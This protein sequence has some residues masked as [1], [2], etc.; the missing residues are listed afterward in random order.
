MLKKTKTPGLETSLR[1]PIPSLLS[2]FAFLFIAALLSIAGCAK[3]GEPQPPEIFIPEAAVDLTANQRAD[4]ILLRV[5]IPR[6]NTN[7]SEVTTL[8]NVDVYRHAA[9]TSRIRHSNPISADQFWREAEQILSI[10]ETR[11]SEYAQQDLL[12]FED[13]FSGLE[14]SLI[15]TH[16]FRYAVLFVNNKKQ[17]AGFSNQAL[18]APVRMPPSPTGLV[19]KVTETSI[20]LQWEAALENIE[21][22]DTE[23]ISGYNI[24]RSTERDRIPPIPVNPA[25]LKRPEY[26]DVQFNFDRTYYYRVSVIDG[27]RDSPAESLLSIEVAVTPRDVF[28]PQPAENINVLP[29]EGFILLLWNPSPSADVAG[30]RITRREEG[31]T[32]RQL[33]NQELIPDHSYRDKDIHSG[34]KYEYVLTAIDTSGNESSAVQAE[35]ETR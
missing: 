32:T 9:D 23:R 20:D 3:M 29:E 30:Y 31:T 7:G 17:A 27:L 13:R 8:Q 14:Q 12:I 15:Y 19:A 1:Q 24:Y 33:L 18:I 10:P 11:I 34:K 21:G 2:V 4:T 22:T 6:R 28:P 26:N 25:P 35:T 16:A 5:S